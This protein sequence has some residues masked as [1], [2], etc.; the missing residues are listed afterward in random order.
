MPTAWS[1]GASEKSDNADPRFRFDFFG[2][3]SLYTAWDTHKG[4]DDA[5]AFALPYPAGSFDATA[6]LASVITLDSKFIIPL[7]PTAAWVD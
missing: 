1:N 2:V 6:L 5:V 3:T 4:D 7:P